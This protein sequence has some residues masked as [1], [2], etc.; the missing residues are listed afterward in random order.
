MISSGSSYRALSHSNVLSMHCKPA[1]SMWQQQSVKNLLAEHFPYCALLLALFGLVLTCHAHNGIHSRGLRQRHSPM[2]INQH[3]NYGC[4][5]VRMLIQVYKIYDCYFS[6]WPLNKIVSRQ[7]ARTHRDS[8]VHRQTSAHASVRTP[9]ADTRATATTTT[10]LVR[11]V[12]WSTMVSH[13]VFIYKRWRL[14]VAQALL[15]AR[16]PPPLY[17]T[18]CTNTLT[19]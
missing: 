9:I 14:H 5:C 4:V 2:G 18:L 6:S 13:Y 19:S 16:H 8:T 10:T 1:V 11:S 7:L 12:Q 3:A 15:V 17:R